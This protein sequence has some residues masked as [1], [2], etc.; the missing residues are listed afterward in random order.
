MRWIFFKIFTS[1]DCV[2]VCMWD[3]SCT[4]HEKLLI[5]TLISTSTTWSFRWILFLLRDKCNFFYRKTPR[6]HRQTLICKLLL[7]ISTLHPLSLS[8][9]STM[10]YRKPKRQCELERE[11]DRAELKAQEK[12][13]KNNKKNLVI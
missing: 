10:L 6:H 9:L 3:V 2:S 7:A 4:H 5:S 12:K 13:K 1:N 11:I 8:F